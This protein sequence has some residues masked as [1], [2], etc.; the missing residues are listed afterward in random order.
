MKSTTGMNQFWASEITEGIWDVQL[1]ERVLVNE[2]R[3]ETVTEAVKMARWKLHLD[4]MFKKI[5]SYH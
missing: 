3:S 4:S 1:G 2:L 5:E